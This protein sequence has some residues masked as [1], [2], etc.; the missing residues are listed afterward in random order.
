MNEF[1]RTSVV[2]DSDRYRMRFQ[3]RDYHILDAIYENDGILTKR[4]I[5]KLF[6]SGMT[7]RA[8]EKRLSKLFHTGY[9]TWPTTKQWRTHPIPEPVCWLD[10]KGIL[11][12]AARK[13]SYIEVK[14]EMNENQLRKLEKSL[15]DKGIRWTREPRWI[16]LE[17]DI[18][19]TDFKISL[20]RE[21]ETTP[22]LSLVKWVSDGTFR[23]SM[24]IIEYVTVQKNGEKRTEKKG[25]CPDGYFEI[26]D[27]S[28]KINNNPAKARF[29][30]EIDMATHDNPSFGREKSI[31]GVAYLRSTA[32]RNRFGYNSGR[33]LI[34]T[35]GNTRMKNLI[36]QTIQS[37][38][39][40]ARVFLF[41]TFDQVQSGQLLTDPIW[42]QPG[43]EEPISLFQKA[44]RYRFNLDEKK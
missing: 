24:D 41:T 1:M 38:G 12:V 18:A 27:Q 21:I 36:Q 16:Q 29:L 8:M 22:S 31:P 40:A 43:N 19:I 10:W 5:Y 7:P 34:V 11:L 23:T 17:H 13:N 42:M 44:L 3:E 2:N 30:L 15:R 26:V 6:W 14:D 28:R 25:I 4:Q 39:N 37:I 9:I 20:L 32:Y 33:W 35:T